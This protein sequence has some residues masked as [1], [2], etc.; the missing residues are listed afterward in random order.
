MALE[1]DFGQRISRIEERLQHVATKEDLANLKADL[2]KWMV[3]AMVLW[4]GVLIAA[5]R[6]IPA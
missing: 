3:I 2:I 6:F 4:S 5:L 1:Q